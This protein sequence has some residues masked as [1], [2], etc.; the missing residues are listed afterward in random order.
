MPGHKIT[1]PYCFEE[2]DDAAVHFRMETVRSDN[3]RFAP[4]MDVAYE[5]FWERYGGTTES[6]SPSRDHTGVEPWQ[7]PVY[8]PNNASDADVFGGSPEFSYGDGIVLGVKDRF[9]EE[10]ERRVC[11]HCHN[12]LPGRYGRY[13]VKFISLIGISG[14]G[15][16]VYLSQLCKFIDKRMGAYNVTVMPTSSYANEYMTTNRVAAEQLLPQPTPPQIFQQPLC[17]DFTFT[18]TE[19]HVHSQTFVFYDIAGENLQFNEGMGGGI[20]DS[21]IR[22]GPFIRHSDAIIMLIDPMQFAG[23][24]DRQDAVTALQIINAMFDEAVLRRMPVAVCISQ[25]DGKPQLPDGGIDEFAPTYC[26]QII[27]APQLPE[28]RRSANEE[29]PFSVEDYNDLRDKIEQFVRDMA[30]STPLATTLRQLYGCYNYFMI[31]S[32]GVPLKEQEGEGGTFM[33]PSARPRPK[34]II[35]P[36][37]WILS[38]LPISAGSH[39]PIVE[40]RGVINEPGDWTCPHCG[41]QH[42]RK[43]EEFCPQCKL[44]RKGQWKCPACGTLNSKDDVWCTKKGCKTDRDGNQKKFLGL[45]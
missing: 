13:P 42:I 30:D 18:D 20:A 28:M 33:V 43:A 44:N 2:F 31:E 24:D 40:F 27:N 22:F 19:G 6:P 25:A 17:F 3:T 21:A 10:T 32:I 1:C 37:L 5:T 39:R 34:R 7:R 38:K 11:P 36:I 8:D 29:Q 16:T 26:L 23:D 35:E 4:R 14:A 9:G 12:P 15:K 41:H 45:F